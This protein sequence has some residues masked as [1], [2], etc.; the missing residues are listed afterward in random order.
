V[1]LLTGTLQYEPNRRQWPLKDL[2]RIGRGRFQETATGVTPGLNRK[3][4][5]WVEVI[6]YVEPERTLCMPVSLS[7][8][9]ASDSSHRT[10]WWRGK[11]NP[12]RTTNASQPEC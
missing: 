7:I 10:A 6:D 12:I 9:F 1:I 2:S 8:F 5:R 3:K 4:S 11:V